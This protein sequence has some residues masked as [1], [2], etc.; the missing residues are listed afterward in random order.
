[1]PAPKSSVI[2]SAQPDGILV[3]WNRPMMATCDIKNQIK[4]IIDGNLETAPVS[5][6]FHPND[7]TQMGIV[8]ATPFTPGQTV[9]WAYDDTGPC[10][11]QTIDT[12]HVEADNQ[13]YTVANVLQVTLTPTADSTTITA[14]SDQ[15]TVDKG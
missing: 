9:T 10:D 14:D 6:E 5:V 2:S 4:V 12:P 3:T 1:M 7:K 15:I 8:M 11:I 13:T